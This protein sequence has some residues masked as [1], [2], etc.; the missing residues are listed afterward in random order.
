MRK[1]AIG[2][3]IVIA[4]LFAVAVAADFVWDWRNQEVIGK[5]DQ[6]LKNTSKLTEPARAE[7]LDAVVLRLQKP[8]ADR[9]YGDERIR[10]IASTTRLRFVELG[11]GKP[12]I[13][14]TSLGLE[15]GCDELNNCPFWIFQ[16]EQDGYV[17]LVD[18]VA[19]SYTVQPTQTNGYSD[20]VLSRH[21]S[22][23]ES[24]LTLYQYDGKTYA[25]G[26]CYVATFAAPKDGDVGEP[27]IA[28]C[29]K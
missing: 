9:G 12:L 4:A 7:L 6:S 21:V 11:G 5:S 25:E 1:R 27:E 14:A 10:E 16:H 24:R 15:G 23:S 13:L 20:L 18:T 3:G 2:L 19:A 22:A 28:G 29:G 26:G 17:S 8:L